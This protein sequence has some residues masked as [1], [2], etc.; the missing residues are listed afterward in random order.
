MKYV[1]MGFGALLVLMCLLGCTKKPVEFKPQ[2]QNQ[3]AVM[4]FVKQKVPNMVITNIAEA[5]KPPNLHGQFGGMPPRYRVDLADPKDA[6]LQTF[7]SVALNPKTN[8]VDET[9]YFP[10]APPRK[11]SK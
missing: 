9:S 10:P 1:A 5:P 2:D 8:Q 3:T 7:T 4:T 11:P 6:S